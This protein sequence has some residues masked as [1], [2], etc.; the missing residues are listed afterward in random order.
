LSDST[1]GPGWWQASDTKWY[2]PHL[3]PGWTPPAAVTDDVFIAPKVV[4]KNRPRRRWQTPAIVATSLLVVVAGVVIAKDVSSSNPAGT[5]PKLVAL[6]GKSPGQILRESLAAARKSVS[7]Q[8]LVS[9]HE[10]GQ[11]E[12]VNIYVGPHGATLAESFAGTSVTVAVV[13]G[14]T[15][16]LADGPF[17]DSYLNLD[18]GTSRFDGD[19]IEVPQSGTG[20][21]LLSQYANAGDLLSNFLEMTGPITESPLRSPRGTVLLRGRLPNSTFN[22]GSGGGILATV[23]VSTTAPFYPVMVSYADADPQSGSGTYTFSHWDKAEAVPSVASAIPLATLEAALKASVPLVNPVP[24][25]PIPTGK[26]PPG[27]V[28]VVVADPTTPGVSVDPAEAYSVARRLWNERILA[29]HYRDPQAL[30][31]V[32]SG[33][34]LA[35]E[36]PIC[37]GGCPAPALYVMSALSIVVNQHAT[38]PVAFLATASYPGGCSENPCDDT[39]VAVQPEMGSRWTIAFVTSYSGTPV[40]PD[41]D[42]TYMGYSDVPV[43]SVNPVAYLTQFATYLQSAKDTGHAPASTWLQPDYFTTGLLTTD[44]VSPAMS[45]A[46]GYKSV[47]RYS[48][49]DSPIYVFSAATDQALVCGTVDW[50]DVDTPLHGG[51][52]LQPPNRLNW[53]PTLAPGVYTRIVNRGLHMDCYETWP[54]A[55]KTVWVVGDWSGS[56]VSTGS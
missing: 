51:V 50:I 12:S 55:P 6:A 21:P 5:A 27:S 32:E 54:A 20:I 18:A 30:A 24:L 2:P 1:Q 29:R 46:D 44:Y 22:D 28:S 13:T 15:Y 8:L 7:F 48:P 16:M 17:W 49:G 10:E 52:L 4:A 43:I 3:H 38:W 35:V 45:L 26:V 36:R 42:Q 25:G 19:W 14:K 9:Q 11:S 33:P 47:V 56:T 39:F 34:A 53:G 23:S 31:L 41:P 40:E 37:L